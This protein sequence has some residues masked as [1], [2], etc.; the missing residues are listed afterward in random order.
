MPR[1]VLQSKP[2]TTE[3]DH[4]NQLNSQFPASPASPPQPPPI[5]PLFTVALSAIPLKHPLHIE[6]SLELIKT[7]VLNRITDLAGTLSNL[8]YWPQ[9]TSVT[10]PASNNLFDHISGQKSLAVFVAVRSSR[11]LL[12][13]LFPILC[14]C[15]GW[16]LA[17]QHASK[18]SRTVPPTVSIET[19]HQEFRVPYRL[20]GK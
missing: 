1:K 3:L 7:K 4:V 19:E 14:I 10:E 11:I 16:W 13:P 15:L 2:R 17:V 12:L 5:S 18:V 8:L 9:P 6:P 20:Y